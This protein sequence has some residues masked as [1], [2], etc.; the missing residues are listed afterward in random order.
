MAD[1]Y[2]PDRFMSGRWK[3]TSGGFEKYLQRGC[4][5][6]DVDAFT[7]SSGK[8]L[9]IESKEWTA[10]EGHPLLKPSSPQGIKKA[11]LYALRSVARQEGNTVWLLYGEPQQSNPLYMLQ[12]GTHEREPE[13]FEFI[14]LP[15]PKMRAKYLAAFIGLWQAEADGRD[16]IV[17]RGKSNNVH[18]E[19]RDIKL[20]RKDIESAWKRQVESSHQEESA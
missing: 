3:W 10:E 20:R 17:H 1:I 11:Q 9:F 4:Q 13:V 19:Y 6:G 7:E 15:T 5:L 18:A 16:H 14:E 12:L 8:H 2:D